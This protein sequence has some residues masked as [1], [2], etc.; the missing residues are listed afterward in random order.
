MLQPLHQGDPQI[1]ATVIVRIIFDIS[2][3]ILVMFALWKVW[4]TSSC[5]S[6]TLEVQ[7]IIVKNEVQA[8]G[9]FLLNIYECDI[10]HAYTVTHKLNLASMRRVSV[11]IYSNTA[12]L[13]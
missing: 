4:L 9:P 1:M 3:L 10:N 5:I 13:C 8:I 2:I 7:A 6:K 11:A 12:R